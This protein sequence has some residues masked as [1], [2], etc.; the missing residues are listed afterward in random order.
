MR[1]VQVTV[2]SRHTG[3]T[4]NHDWRYIG[5]DEC[6]YTHAPEG[7][8]LLQKFGKLGDAPYYVRTHH[9]FCTGNGH[10]TYKWGST[11]AYREDARGNPVYNWEVIDEIL[12]AT[13]ESNCKPFVELG[14][15]P[16]D[17][18]DPEKLQDV[19]VWEKYGRYKNELWAH[20]PKDYMKWHGLVYNLVKHCV[21]KYGEDEVLTWYWELWNEPDIF[22]W[23]GTHE[24]F[25]K[26]YD[27]TEAA[28]HS[29]L[30]A[31]KLGGPSTT[32]PLPGGP[33]EWYLKKFLEH[34]ASGTNYFSGST[35]TRLDYVTF[36]VKGGG[37]QFN[38]DAPKATPSLKS[39][40]E[41]VKLGLEV[42]KECGFGGLEVV[43]SEADPDGW[44]AG[45]IYDNANMNFRN[46]EYYASYVAASYCKIEELAEEF[47]VAVKPLAW[48][49]LFVG[50]RCFEGTRSFSTQGIN[51]SVF[52]LFEMYGKLGWQKLGLTS[53]GDANVMLYKDDFGTGEP[54]L[55]AGWATRADDDKIQ[56]LIVSHHDD[57]DVEA[58]QQ[59]EL[60]VENPPFS[61]DIASMK[62]FRIDES[63]SNAYTEWVKQGKPKY[64]VGQQYEAIQEKARLELI[65]TAG[66]L[67]VQAGKIRM[68][69]KLPA[70][71]VS[72]IEIGR[73]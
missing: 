28:V 7:K 38:L 5:Y 36:H 58:E 70:H 52:H 48:A 19:N 63:H 12:D 47:Q 56:I 60:T 13:L 72:L 15:M 24:E 2:D 45:G 40:V 32:G 64:P 44:A 73:N 14:F 68:T 66:H 65:E 10:G 27:Y 23:K 39:L 17:L 4:L 42:I 21:D 29:V 31:A 18:I 57:W 43:L 9:L 35:G 67:E 26:L 22:Y 62:H 34:C 16:L 50:E 25:C 33:S 41:Q 1:Q 37:F 6:N 51:K 11:N 54:P 61:G 30:S 69:F 55:V 49:F 46:T 71:A 53:T 59:I 3:K 20:P 8:V